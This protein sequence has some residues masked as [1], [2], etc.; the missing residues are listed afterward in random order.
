MPRIEVLKANTQHLGFAEAISA[1]IEEA[2]KNKGSGLAIRTPEYI[3]TKISEGKS[4]IAFVDGAVAGFCYVE[5]WGHG[6]YVANSG[7]IVSPKYRGMGLAKR[8]K[9]VAFLLSRELFPDAKLFGL[10]TSLAVMKINSDLGYK[11]VTFS[12]LTDDEAFWKGCQ[13]CSH[14]DILQRTNRVSCLCTGMLFDP[15]ND[16]PENQRAKKDLRT[17]ARWFRFKRYKLDN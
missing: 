7:L 13:T 4:V 9:E 10:T 11:P 12:E 1:M 5:T 6:K 16:H 15:R 14:Y 17:F 3:R 2:S 8:I